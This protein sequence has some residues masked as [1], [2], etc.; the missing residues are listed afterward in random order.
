MFKVYYSK[1]ESK[2]KLVFDIYD[3]DS[4]GFISKEDIRI[5]LSH[6]PLAVNTF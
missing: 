2:I 1:L 6:I 5:V 4:D 3:F